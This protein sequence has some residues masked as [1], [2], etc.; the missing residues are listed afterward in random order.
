MLNN[1]EMLGTEP[2]GKLLF[3]FALST[4]IAQLCSIE[5]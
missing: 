5:E 3:Q 4:V 2:V 1:K